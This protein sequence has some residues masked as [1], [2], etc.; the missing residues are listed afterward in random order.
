MNFL[1]NILSTLIGLFIFSFIAIFLVVGIVSSLSES[2]KYVLEDNS[3][4][5]LKLN[6]PVTEQEIDNPLEEIGAFGESS[7]MGLN[8]LKEVIKNAASDSKI[9][10]IYLEVEYFI[11]GM[12]TLS[13]VRH[14]L[15]E[16][17]KS[18]KFIYSYAEYYTEGAY[19]LASVAD[20]IYLNPAGQLELNGLSA[21]VTFYKGM[22]DK[23]GIEP[24]VFRVGE[25]KSAV[26]PFIRKDLS[27]ENE[28][29]LTEL[30]DGLNNK[31]LA[32]ISESRGIELPQLKEMSAKM[33]VREAIDAVE[34]KLIDEII[35]EDELLANLSS[36]AEVD[37]P[38]L[39]SYK[40]YKTTFSNYKNTTNKIAVIVAEGDIVM[41]K[42]DEN[43]VGS[44]KF[45]KLIREA[46]K[47]KSVK[48]IVMRVNSLG[49]AFLASDVM[50]REIELA[51]KEKPV[52]ASMGDYA[53]SGGYYLAMPC[54]TIVAQ[55]NTITGSIGIFGML[56]NFS[57]LLED[58]IGITHDEVATGEYSGILTVTRSLT[59]AEKSIFQKS[60]EQNYDTFVS[61]A[62]EGRGMSVE[63][64]KKVASGRVWTGVQAKENGLIDL[65]GTYDDAI[66]IAAEKA[67]ITDD[68][69][70][71]YYPESKPFFEKLIQDLEGQAKTSMVKSEV[72]ELYP[73]IKSIE[74]I[75]HFEGA[76][77]RFPIEME[78]N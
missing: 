11:G 51:K 56:F 39:V 17:K 42:G 71:K 19:Y 29:Q 44:D 1:K 75:K 48:A 54:D 26:E 60:L 47:D 10:G 55:P 68:Y 61:K 25:Y 45:A 67:G 76:Q 24:Q 49:G 18:G 53:T 37:E 23:F 66:Q 2:E 12:A 21:N 4:L 72:G 31:M 62:A 7:S 3:I 50:W 14:E 41:G 46:R 77:A 8:K 74:K 20:K 59:D 27:P 22:F 33:T 43:T 13:E 6:K 16:F 65:L 9:K 38:E 57:G 32:D 28:L 70:L 73:Y 63:D 78:I 58:R 69:K 5:H 15:V 36:A 30:L 40:N 35:Y 52:I 64:I 34:Q